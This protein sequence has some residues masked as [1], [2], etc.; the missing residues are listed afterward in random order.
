MAVAGQHRRVEAGDDVAVP[1]GAPHTW[2]K[3]SAEPAHALVRLTPSCLVDE[4]FAALCR[5]ASSGRANRLGLP[6]N[7]LQFAVVFDRHRDEIALASPL[8]QS[9]AT[10]AVRALAVLG[11]AAGFRADGSRSRSGRD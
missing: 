4:F 1:I 7:P 6:R 5:V 2:G 3:T 9:F 10:P 11:R 8:A